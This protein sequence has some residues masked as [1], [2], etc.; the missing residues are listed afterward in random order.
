MTKFDQLF[1]SKMEL[2][3]SLNQSGGLTKPFNR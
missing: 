1:G 3:P 2:P